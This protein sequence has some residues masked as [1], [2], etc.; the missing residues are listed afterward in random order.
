MRGR[1]LKAI[2]IACII[3]A[4]V[5]AVF[6]VA[7]SAEITDLKLESVEAVRAKDVPQLA[8][9]TTPD[10]PVFKV[11]FSTSRDLVA[12]A[13]GLDRYTIRNRVLVGEAACNP[14]LKV[15]SYTMAADMLVDFTKVYDDSGD[16]E[17]RAVWAG[18]RGQGADGYTYQFYF[19]VMP[20]RMSEFL[21]TGLQ[22]AP[23]CFAL[24]GDSRTGRQFSSNVV[25]LPARV[26]GAAATRLVGFMGRNLP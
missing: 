19:G 1:A 7:S 4:A 25:P 16:V 12:L 2:V 6:Y 26:L 18:S 24:T 15:L 3:G 20:A 17:G 23:I 10:T 22:E 8:G 14:D 13:N 5:V 9:E 21:S 11:R